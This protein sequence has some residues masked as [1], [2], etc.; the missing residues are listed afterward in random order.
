MTD[1]VINAVLRESKLLGNFLSKMDEITAS[2]VMEYL[3]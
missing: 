3:A 2:C 1:I